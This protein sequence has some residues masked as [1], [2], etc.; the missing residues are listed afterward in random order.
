MRQTPFAWVNL[1]NAQ[2]RERRVLKIEWILHKVRCQ[3]LNLFCALSRVGFAVSSLAFAAASILW[4]DLRPGFF[5]WRNTCACKEIVNFLYSSYFKWYSLLIMR[6]QSYLRTFS[7]CF[8]NILGK[9]SWQLLFLELIETFVV[10]LS[11]EVF[12]IYEGILMLN[13]QKGSF[14]IYSFPAVN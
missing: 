11:C 10:F 14:K 5:L 8:K 1:Q 12:Y 3:R 13:P 9:I 7:D 6:V 4:R 2:T